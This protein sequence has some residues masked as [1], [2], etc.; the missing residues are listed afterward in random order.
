VK[1]KQINCKD[2]KGMVVDALYNYDQLS[3]EDK[4]LFHAHLTTCPACAGEYE[5]MAGVLALMDQRDRPGIG[6]EF[7]DSFYP[8]LLEKIKKQE[9]QEKVSLIKSFWESRTLFSKRVLAAGGK[10]RRWMLY[11]AA[12]LLLVVIGIAIGRYLYLPPVPGKGEELISGTLSS[13]SKISPVVLEHFESLRPLLIDCA[14]YNAQE[15]GGGEDFVLIDKKT[16]KTLALQNLLLKRIAARGHDVVL[17]QVLEELEMILLELSN[18][19][20]GES[21]GDVTGKETMGRV[22][23]IL[24]K[25]DTLFKMKSYN[26]SEA[27]RNV[28]LKI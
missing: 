6:E 22:R 26:K 12:A 23:E 27:N 14:N 21:D 19:E 28:Q 9:K 18:A 24:K 5:E 2:F 11:P 1:Q 17:T 15:T 7:W 10:V 25:N 8:R 16:L 20:P 4:H 3:G 13:E